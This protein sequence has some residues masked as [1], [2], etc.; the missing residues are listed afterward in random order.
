MGF[1]GR[2]PTP[3]PLTSSDIPDL[4]ATKITSG[5]FPAIDGSN[6]T[7][8][9]TDFVKVAT[10][11]GTAQSSLSSI[12][13]ALDE[14]YAKF[15]LYWNWKP[16]TDNAT[17]LAYLSTD[18]GSSYYTSSNNYKYGTDI[19]YVNTDSVSDV[20]Y[21]DGNNQIK[22]SKEVGNNTSNGE[23]NSLTIDISPIMTEGSVNQSNRI[24]W[25][26]TRM[27]DGN[28]IRTMIGTATLE[29]SYVLKVNKIKLQPGSG[30]IEDYFY[31][32]YGMKQ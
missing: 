7:G 31:T 24:T 21:S 10:A 15:L 16:E 4:P 23:G 12:E 32:L 19:L 22:L 1:I 9:S 27:S 14:S 6:L 17:L 20:D 2:V 11:S 26:G 30:N 29:A 28:G 25:W 13:I 18:N 8:I 3:I 5:A